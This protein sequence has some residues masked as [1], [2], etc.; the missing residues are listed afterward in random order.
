MYEEPSQLRDKE[1]KILKKLDDEKKKFE[2]EKNN[3]VN[4]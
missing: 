4:Q 2:E 3:H 1:R